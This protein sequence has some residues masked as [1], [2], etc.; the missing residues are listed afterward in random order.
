MKKIEELILNQ[1]VINQTTK[2]I[3]RHQE[4]LKMFLET[5]KTLQNEV[6]EQIEEELKRG[7]HWYEYYTEEEYQPYDDEGHDIGDS[8]FVVEA[9]LNLESDIVIDLKWFMDGENTWGEEV[10]RVYVGEEDEDLVLDYYEVLK[11]LQKCKLL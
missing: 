7:A 11:V 1:L 8:H 6:L 3:N 4:R 10:L 9:Q 2:M 5:R